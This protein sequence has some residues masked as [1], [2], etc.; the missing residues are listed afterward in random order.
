MVTKG[1]VV[2]HVAEGDPHDIGKNI[3]AV[4]LRSNGYSVVDMGRDVPVDDVVNKVVETSPHMV[5][6]TALMTT[7]MAAFPKI[8]ERLLEK[9]VELPFV[10]AGGAVN[11]AYVE[12]FPLGVFAEKAM[13]GP[14]LAAKAVEGWDYKKI[15]SKW[16]ELM[17]GKA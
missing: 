1:T 8:A 12:S 10:C 4:L 5:T 14:T 3:A 7:T 13:Q 15:R 11:R 9:G 17:S 6:G 2:M 16:D